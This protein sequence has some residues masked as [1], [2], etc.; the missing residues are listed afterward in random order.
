[1]HYVTHLESAIDGT[2]LPA[3]RVQ[4]LHADRPLWVRY[5]LPA[6]K[7]AVSPAD[8]AGREP[9]LWRYRELLPEFDRLNRVRGA[10]PTVIAA[11]ELANVHSVE[12]L[13]AFM[14]D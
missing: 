7:K 4:T 6:V 1:M 8:L 9:S 13:D 5:D 10:G 2:H 14:T 11:M 12:D 3:D